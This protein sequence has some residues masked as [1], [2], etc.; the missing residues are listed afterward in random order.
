MFDRLGIRVDYMR[1]PGNPDD[2]IG[3]NFRTHVLM[4]KEAY[5]KGL[6]HVLIF[7]DDAEDR[8]CINQELIDGVTSFLSINDDWDVFYL[9]H[10]PDIFF[11]SS[12]RIRNNIYSVRSLCTH[13]YIVSRRF[14]KKMVSRFSYLLDVQQNNLAE[15]NNDNNLIQLNSDNIDRLNNDNIDRLNND[16]ID[17]LNNDNIDRLN[18]RTQL[19]NDNIDRLNSLSRSETQLYESYIRDRKKDEPIDN[20]I[21]DVATCYAIYPMMF[22]Q[23]DSRSDLSSIQWTMR[24][25]TMMAS[26]GEW[27]MAYLSWPG[28][29]S[30]I[31]VVIIVI[32]LF[33]IV[34]NRRKNCS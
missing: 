27:H 26:F 14:M 16:N 1:V 24:F 2:R 25:K 3:D 34:Y 7:E 18:N 30:L 8:E 13:A 17:R 9:G 6:N 21:K 19:G 15:L 32:F 10:Q 12:M 5:D 11:V 4:M 22:H 31:I 23:S 29:I 33:F 20:Y 28:Y